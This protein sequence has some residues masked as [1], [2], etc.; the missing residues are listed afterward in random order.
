M[1]QITEV[2]REHE[3]ELLQI[4]CQ[5]IHFDYGQLD[6][7]RNNIDKIY[8]VDVNNTPQDSPARTSLNDAEYALNTIAHTF[9]EEFLPKQS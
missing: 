7:L 1:K 3:I 4:F 5:T 6:E 8:V 9:L 2:L